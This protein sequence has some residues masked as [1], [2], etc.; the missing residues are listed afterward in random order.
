MDTNLSAN[1]LEFVKEHPEEVDWLKDHVEH[2]FW[3]K[4][5]SLLNEEEKQL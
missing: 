5:V 1:D 2:K 3:L 4:L